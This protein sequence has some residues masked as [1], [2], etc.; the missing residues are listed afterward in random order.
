MVGAE[1]LSE[2]QSSVVSLL[3]KSSNKD[4]EPWK[5]VGKLSML[6]SISKAKK[7]KFVNDD[8]VCSVES[9]KT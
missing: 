6:E 5:K 8:L 3:W 7:V 4:I 2:G 1:K 9:K